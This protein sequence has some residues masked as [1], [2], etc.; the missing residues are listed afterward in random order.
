MKYDCSKTLD[1]AHEANRMCETVKCCDS[2]PVGR[3]RG[4]TF[5]D[6]ITQKR[7][8]IV[9]KWSDEH[10]EKTRKE[11]FREI[12]PHIGIF[13]PQSICFKNLVGF[14]FGDIVKTECA[15]IGCVE[16]WNEPYAGEFEKAREEDEAEKKG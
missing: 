2:C 9:Q 16:C 11:A 7:I 1:Y 12:F 5:I 4:C 10:S 13:D 6:K 8:D 14:D 15:E 3:G